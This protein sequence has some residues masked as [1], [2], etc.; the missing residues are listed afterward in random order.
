MKKQ[1]VHPYWDARRLAMLGEFDFVDDTEF[2]TKRATQGK[3]FNREL[4]PEVNLA[5]AVIIQA[6]RDIA[7]KIPKATTRH[8]VEKR[9][10]ALANRADAKAFLGSEDE[11]FWR[12]FEVF[13]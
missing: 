1:F 9:R 5:K 3:R 7:A 6:E 4:R 12:A 8:T 2:H 11:E 10:Q 13:A